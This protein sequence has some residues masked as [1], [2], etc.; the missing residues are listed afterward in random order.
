MTSSM[1]MTSS[2]ISNSSCS[3][4]AWR[5]LQVTP[6]QCGVRAAGV[7]AFASSMVDPSVLVGFDDRP[8]LHADVFADVLQPVR[9]RRNG[10]D[11]GHRCLAEA[12]VLPDPSVDVRAVVELG[13][14]YVNQSR[15]VLLRRLY[16]RPALREK[17]LL[18]VTLDDVPAQLKSPA[19]RDLLLRS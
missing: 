19:Q 3:T 14:R 13:E 16:H 12:P 15:K 6:L 9:D 2:D 17:R 4:R 18:L 11:L 10:F 1:L 7:Q 8:E 5:L